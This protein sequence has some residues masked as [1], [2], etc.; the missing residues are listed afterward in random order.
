MPFLGSCYLQYF[1]Y[2]FSN[3]L[4]LLL[5]CDTRICHGPQ[6]SLLYS[7]R[8]LYLG[9]GIQK[10]SVPYFIATTASWVCLVA[11]DAGYSTND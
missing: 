9:K 11:T 4:V 3:G 5:V 2:A 1:G 10:G 8:P 6:Y 7:Y